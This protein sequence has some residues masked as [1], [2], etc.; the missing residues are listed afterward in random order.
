MSFGQFM[1]HGPRAN[2]EA[3][4]SNYPP[5]KFLMPFQSTPT[6]PKVQ[7]LSKLSKSVAYVDT[8]N[9]L[10]QK[11][12]DVWSSYGIKALFLGCVETALSGYAW[13]QYT[14]S[15]G[16][17]YE[18]MA[19]ITLTAFTAFTFFRCFESG[20][21]KEQWKDMLPKYL[22]ER[23]RCRDHRYY[24]FSYLK[25]KDYKNRLLSQ[26]EVKEIWHSSVKYFRER[27]DF[28]KTSN[29]P[30][31]ILSF[32]DHFYKHCPLDYESIEYAGVQD[33][34]VKALQEK[35]QAMRQNYHDLKIEHEKQLNAIAKPVNQTKNMVRNVED[36]AH[37]VAMLRNAKKNQE[38]KAEAKEKMKRALPQEIHGIRK[39]LR[40][41][42][43]RNSFT[44][45]LIQGATRSI[46]KMHQDRLSEQ[47]EAA[48]K[49]IRAQHALE[50][51]SR[52]SKD[53]EALFTESLSTKFT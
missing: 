20:R 11:C 14:E 6:D 50:L 41:Q 39:T 9:D 16:A 53:L 44:T 5:A 23:K 42:R 28:M 1:L 52:F 36:G 40:N 33:E 45:G 17:S 19:A 15:E 35:F 13:F 48:A 18:L 51:N 47:L 37:L 26:T 30:N 34:Q 7:E 22:E 25:E 27:F 3:Q 12:S 49:P 2:P 8:R 43:W 38:L 21:Q 29:S 32:F 10:R 4:R 31:E 24:G 46:A